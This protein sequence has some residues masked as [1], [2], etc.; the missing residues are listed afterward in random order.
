[1]N[2]IYDKLF[3]LL[4][5]AALIAGGVYYYTTSGEGET[6]GNEEVSLEAADN[7]YD[8][9]PVPEIKESDPNWPEPGEQSTGWRYDVFTPPK[10][11]LDAEGRFSA[12]PYTPPEPPEPFGVY[13]ADIRREPYRLQLEGYVQEDPTDPSKSLLLFYDEKREKIVRTRVDE[14]NPESEFEVLEFTNKR[15]RNEDGNYDRVTEV[16][17]LDKRSG[18]EVTLERGERQYVGDVTI[19]IRSNE[20]P[21]VNLEFGEDDEGATFE[22][23]SGKYILQKINLEEETV[24]IQ[25]LSDSEEEDSEEGEEE[26]EPETKTL[27]VGGGSAGDDGGEDTDSEADGNRTDE[28]G[29]EENNRPQDDGSPAAD[30]FS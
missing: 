5:L 2:K 9:V 22:T 7:P 6:M 21:D 30:I 17:I 16:R 24:T 4:A 14:K 3:L 8:P 23:P 20:D 10:I 28:G 18:E 1:M 19:V 29:S 15:V 11:Y 25:K 27:G 12:E 13:L 26:E